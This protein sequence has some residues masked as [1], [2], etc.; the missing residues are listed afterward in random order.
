MLLRTEM[1]G[2][3]YRLRPGID[4]SL[5]SVP[6]LRVPVPVVLHLFRVGRHPLRAVHRRLLRT[7]AFGVWH[8]VMD[9]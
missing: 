6:N 2:F 9:A 1:I 3:A 8:E 4:R 7:S 5:N